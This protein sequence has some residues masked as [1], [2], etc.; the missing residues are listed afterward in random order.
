MINGVKKSIYIV[1][2]E[3]GIDFWKKACLA[4]EKGNLLDLWNSDNKIHYAKDILASGDFLIT[5][6]LIKSNLTRFKKNWE[7]T[8]NLIDGESAIRIAKHLDR[9]DEVHEI[10]ADILVMRANAP[11]CENR[12]ELLLDAIIL[13]KLAKRDRKYWPL[14]IELEQWSDLE[15]ELYKRKNHPFDRIMTDFCKLKRGKIS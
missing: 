15:G 11:D 9:M 10:E 5:E 12:E 3:E 13:Y 2:D 8:G 14:M 6:D 1:E 4:D 7:S